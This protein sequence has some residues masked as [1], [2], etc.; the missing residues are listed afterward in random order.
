MNDEKTHLL[1][2]GTRQKLKSVQGSITIR[3]AAGDIHPIVSEK[4]LGVTIQNDLKW[5][6]YL[7][8]G[9]NSLV[10]Q[11]STRLSAVK[12]ISSCTSFKTRLMVANG[13]II[14][15]LI[16]MI[17]LWGGAESYLLNCLQLVQNRAARFVTQ[18]DKYT[19]IK[20]LLTECGWLSV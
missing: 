9:D 18:R 16:Y 14:S 6:E 3:T 1:L 10:K 11:L 20:Q 17:G 13:I 4:L 5:S 7:L 12:L 2:M 19:P 15:K 8:K